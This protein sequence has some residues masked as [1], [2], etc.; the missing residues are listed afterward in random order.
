[1]F[2]C[3]EEAFGDYR[4]TPPLPSSCITINNSNYLTKKDSGGN[5]GG[6]GTTEQ[7]E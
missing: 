6:R 5:Y 4:L 3:T 7:I 1:M 2:N